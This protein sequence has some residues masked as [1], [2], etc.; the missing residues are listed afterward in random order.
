MLWNPANILCMKVF[1]FWI[2]D[3]ESII[4]FCEE[5]FMFLLKI[6]FVYLTKL[7]LPK[8]VIRDNANSQLSVCEPLARRRVTCPVIRQRREAVYTVL[9]EDRRRRRRRRR[10]R[11]WWWWRWG[12]KETQQSWLLLFAFSPPLLFR[13]SCLIF[14]TCG[15]FS[16]LHFGG[17]SF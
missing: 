9:R 6:I 12:F 5:K 17:K 10:R 3:A 1:G 13:F 15:A 7:L 4:F 8:R 14:F 2:H 11:W 16:R